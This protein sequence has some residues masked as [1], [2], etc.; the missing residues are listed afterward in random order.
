M[1][2]TLAEVARERH[3]QDVTWGEQN[4]PHGTGHPDDRA[5]ADDLRRCTEAAAADGTLSWRH[6]LLEEVGEA[7]AGATTAELREELVQVAATAVCWI[8]A[9]DRE[10]VIEPPALTPAVSPAALSRRP[11]AGVA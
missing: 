9:I 8:Q 4:H 7:F 3:R 2:K 1:I 11:R 10:T 6:I 5:A